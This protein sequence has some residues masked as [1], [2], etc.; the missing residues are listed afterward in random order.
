M[1][2]NKKQVKG[3]FLKMKFEDQTVHVLYIISYTLFE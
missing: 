1:I 3:A 2:E